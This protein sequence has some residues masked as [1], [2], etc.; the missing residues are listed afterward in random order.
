M[1]TKFLIIILLS[2]AMIVG[3]LSVVFSIVTERHREVLFNETAARLAYTGREL[4]RQLDSLKT[5]SK[6][7]AS[8]PEVQ[9]HMNTLRSTSNYSEKKRATQ[10]LSIYLQQMQYES[11]DDIVTFL[12]L[13]T[14][15]TQIGTRLA[16]TGRMSPSTHSSILQQ[17]LANEGVPSFINDEKGDFG[18]ILIRA[19]RQASD[20]S[21]NN[22][23][24]VLVGVDIRQLMN[25]TME[26]LTASGN[27][28]LILHS[29]DSLF[30]HSDSLDEK[31]ATTISR[32]MKGDYGL[33]P[34]DGK[35]YFAVKGKL[36]SY[37]W[38]YIYLLDYTSMQQ[39]LERTQMFVLL[40]MVFITILI[41]FLGQG[42]IESTLRHLD[43]LMSKIICFRKQQPIEPLFV[44]DYSDR[45]DELG[46]LHNQFDAMTDRINTLI[47]ENYKN[48]LLKQKAELQALRAQIN[49][50]FLYNTL[51]SINWNAKAIGADHISL[52]VESL[53][54][55]LRMSISNVDA[56]FTVGDAVEMQEAYLTIQKIRYEKRLEYRI[57]IPEEYYPIPVPRLILQP[58]V[59]N[60]VRYGVEENLDTTFILITAKK[61]GDDLVFTVQNSGS[62]FP[63]DLL[64]NLSNK[65]VVPHGF[66]IGLLN[67][68]KRL[69]YT[70]GDS[71]G[72]MLE[73]TDEMATVHIRVPISP[74]GKGTP[75][76]ETD[77]R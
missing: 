1:R 46:A 41:I 40:C 56:P 54:K 70:Y 49:P 62:E 43:N 8:S 47:R 5:L 26:N 37:G 39:L 27:Q 9:M 57:D 44:F 16:S 25:R 12:S 69:R 51:N 68:H 64:Q 53:G 15:I 71:Y 50:H 67:I 17:A 66:G 21:L 10:I 76:A 4:E 58:I 60:A 77:H 74:E 34:Y 28:A 19:V 2:N 31:A 59:E 18:L 22:L 13:Q 24:A 7:I 75:H 61:D 11:P 3:S 14:P 65:T 30:Y 35:T 38:S 6:T 29:G 32:D 52:M 20:L 72:L 73:N 36:A 23:G 55:I 63:D 45:T 48:E 42:A 33:L